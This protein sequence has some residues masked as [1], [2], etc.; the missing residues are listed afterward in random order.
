MSACAKWTIPVLVLVHALGDDGRAREPVQ[1]TP[2]LLI[3]LVDDLG[4]TDVGCYGSMFYETTHIDG[5]ARE[6]LRFTNGYAACPVC[7]PTRVSLQTG[8]HPARLHTT[9]WFGGFQPNEA[10][11][12]PWVKQFEGRRLLPAPYVE[13]LPLEERTLAE[14]L[15]PLGYQTFF[16]GKWHL[17]GEGY[18]PEDQGYQW[19]LGGHE[20][21]TPPGGYFSPYHNPKLPDGPVGEHLPQRLAKEASKFLRSLDEQPFLLVLSFYSVHNP[22]Q[23]RGDLVEKY[24][25]K[26]ARLRSTTPEFAPE[27]TIQNRQVQ[28]QPV[29][30]AMVEAVDLAVGDVLST[31]TELDRDRKTVVLFTSDNGGLS[32]A[33]GFPTSNVPLRAGKGWMYEGGIRVPWL[34]RWPG[35]THPG[36]VCDEP[37]VSTDIFP[38]VLEM[39]DVQ[40]PEQAPLDGVS[41]VP[42]LKDA[43][44]RLRR[45]LY[46]HY[47]HYSHQGVTPGGAIR[48]GNWKL[49]EWYEDHRLELYDLDQDLGERHDL[50]ASCPERTREL[51]AK[52][53]GWR[54]TIGARMPTANPNY[55]GRGGTRK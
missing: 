7:S 16:A 25:T 44:T 45:D 35:V 26:A 41:L 37:I 33:E 31:L 39:L 21:G 6:S 3:F 49:I 29:Y 51:H 48:S 2:N 30:A 11:Q 28:N 10:L 46:W 52:L 22:Q 53:V 43:G 1:S 18:Y 15:S 9:D 38:T 23:G 17:G 19:N 8:R 4:W 24:E 27:G 34:I 55:T 32:T 42:L 47:P 5:L 14:V 50:A 54:E 40:V 36:T 12:S 13:H 20:R